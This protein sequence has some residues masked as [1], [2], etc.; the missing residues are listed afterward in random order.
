[1]A[2]SEAGARNPSRRGG[3]CIGRPPGRV[4]RLRLE[5]LN[6]LR[7]PREGVG[8]VLNAVDLHADRVPEACELGP[9]GIVE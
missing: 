9:P 6:R 1:M 2:A 3:I 7:Q 4:T 5:L 8:E